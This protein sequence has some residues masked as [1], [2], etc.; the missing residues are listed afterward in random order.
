MSALQVFLD[1]VNVAADFFTVVMLLDVV[2]LFI[3][4]FM[5]KYDPRTFLAWLILLIFLPPVGII[6]YMYMG[7]AWYKKRHLRPKSITDQ[8]MMDGYRFFKGILDEDERVLGKTESVRMARI[9]ESAGG[10]G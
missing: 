2:A 3:M 10:W 6:L 7:M 4:L 8:E 9:M 1:S 5:E